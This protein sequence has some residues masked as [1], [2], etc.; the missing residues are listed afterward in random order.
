MEVW[1]VGHWSEVYGVLSSGRPHSQS[2]LPGAVRNTGDGVGEETLFTGGTRLD[3]LI[4]GH[5][6]PPLPSD[7]WRCIL[8]AFA[9]QSLVLSEVQWVRFLKEICWPLLK[10]NMK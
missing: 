8:E 9:A 4:P 7:V 3:M 1:T 6:P 2:T 5:P 10:V